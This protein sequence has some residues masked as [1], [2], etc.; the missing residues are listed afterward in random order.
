PETAMMMVA[1]AVE[2]EAGIVGG[3]GLD[4]D[5]PELL[6]EVGM[7][8]DQFAYPYAGLEEGE[9]DQGQHDHRRDTLYVTSACMLTSRALVERVGLW[10]GGYFAFGEDLDLC[11]RA[12]IAGFRVLVQPAAHFRHAVALANGLRDCPAAS[13]IRFYTRRN[14]PRT[15]AKNAAAY[16]L[17][18]ILLAYSLLATAEMV[19]LA[20]FRRFDELASYPRAFISFLGALPDI[21][22]RRRA[23]QKRRAAPDRRLRRLMVKD[24]HRARVFLERRARDW[25]RGTLA[26]GKRTFAHLAPRAIKASMSAWIRKPSTLAFGILTFAFVYATRSTLT[27]AP[28]AS[29]SIWP[30]PESTGRLLKAYAESWRNVGLGTES[31]AP[32]ALPLMWVVSFASLGKALLAQKLLIIALSLAGAVGMNRLVSR[33]ATS[34]QARVVA[35]VVYALGP[36]VQVIFEQADLAALALFATA[37]FALEVGLRMMGT[38]PSQEGERPATGL[39]VY[40]MSRDLMRLSLITALGVAFAPSGFVAL[41][42]LWVV[43]VVHSLIGAWDKRETLRR[44]LWVLAC[45]PITLLLMMPWSLEAFRPTGA[46]LGPLFSSSY[47]DL[48]SKFDLRAFVFLDPAHPWTAV[49]MIAGITVGALVVS[50]RVRRRESRLL[51]VVWLVF[52]IMGTAS[53]RGFLPSLVVSPTLWLVIPLVAISLIAA[54]LVAGTQDELPRHAV[55]WRHL[56]AGI[57]GFAMLGGVV[58]GWVPELSHWDRPTDT[59]ASRTKPGS[60]ADSI[61][62]YLLTKSKD[63]G[64]F[65]VLWLG[66][67]WFDPILSGTRPEATV[68]YFLTDPGGLTMLDV[69]PPPTTA[70]E[71]ELDNTVASL[72]DLRL[73]LAG[74]LLAPANI[75]YLIVDPKDEQS[76]TSLRRQRDIA[77]EQQQSDVAIFVNLQWLP[78]AVLAPEGIEGALGSKADPKQLMTAKWSGGE[79]IPRSSASSFAGSI[80]KKHSSHLL[81]SE[82]FNTGWEAQLGGRP[83]EHVRSFGWSNRFVIPTRASGSVTVAFG[84]RWVRALWLVLQALIMIVAIAMARSARTDVKGWLR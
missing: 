6:L 7:S 80:P 36:L 54:H 30:F 22:R 78:R 66:R 40:T 17:P 82:N 79:I 41:L 74:H 8:A 51:T 60:V 49:M 23:V 4:W 69:M 84:N 67:T 68:P 27:G 11:V 9:I 16:R 25:E 81:L 13:D 70:G 44:G 33:R 46:I 10:D 18:F 26:L 83:L 59:L 5:R 73:H 63:V 48:W 56:A 43:V 19:F 52:V 12:R 21:V 20:S 34:L 35:V 32:V 77:L 62:S 47:D 65:R 2:T 24:L 29:G 15:I 57:F 37:P 42:A 72:V 53:A 1:A 58:L 71:K 28:I 55:G 75:R 64:D 76:M 50:G 14:R 39:G 61:S 3:K 45:L 31:A 38:V